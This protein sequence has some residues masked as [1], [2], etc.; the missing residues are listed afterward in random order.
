MS[1]YSTNGPDQED[2][3]VEVTGTDSARRI[4]DE[5]HKFVEATRQKMQNQIEWNEHKAGQLRDEAALHTDAAAALRQFLYGTDADAGEAEVSEEEY[6]AIR[7]KRNQKRRGVPTA[8]E[9]L[10]H[11]DSDYP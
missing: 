1:T 5:A 9:L 7:A 3:E 2:A 10:T 4:N 6:R 8:D 11:Q